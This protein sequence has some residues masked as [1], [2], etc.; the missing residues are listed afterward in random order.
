[1][2]LI[3]LL[4]IVTMVV[5]ASAGVDVANF[6]LKLSPSHVCI[7]LAISFSLVT[8]GTVLTFSV[9]TIYTYRLIVHGLPEGIS[10]F[11][12]FLP[13]GALG[14]AGYAYLLMGEISRTLFPLTNTSLVSNI[15][16]DDIIPRFIYFCAW[17]LAFAM[18]SFA[19]FWFLLAI[20]AL[21]DTPRLVSLPF[22]I[23]FWGTLFPNVRFL[24]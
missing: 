7:T 11:S 24:P 1:M 18:W 4:P 22:T 2:S 16:A 5:A 21:G 12:A 13:L 15:F 19:T 9:L 20:L 3:W 23:M 10:I 17:M 6:M 8:I 14:Q